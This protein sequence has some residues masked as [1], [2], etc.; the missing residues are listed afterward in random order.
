M[1]FWTRFSRPATET[2][3]AC[4]P[5]TSDYVAFSDVSLTR[6][7][8]EV[9]RNV[10]FEL[11]EQRIGL[12]GLN[13]SGK[14]S[15]VR[16]LNGLLLPESGEVRVLGASTAAVRAS[17]P[18]HV[19]FVFQNP[20]HQAIFPTVE[21][22]VVFGL[23]QLGHSRQ[24]AREKA[25]AY[26]VA[27]G[28]DHLA[29]KPFLD[30]SEG[31]KQLICILSVLVMEPEI[32]VL[33]EPFSSLDALACRKIM[34]RLEALP[35]K[36]IMISHDLKLIEGFDRILW[37]EEGQIRMDGTPETVLPA[38]LADVD[39]RAEAGGEIL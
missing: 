10:S 33:D 19:G 36:L 9:L 20:D 22:E 28:C 39:A 15:L 1:A 35:Q 31:Q 5:Q 14:S 13:G 3:V 12:V 24:E 25:R 32:L 7:G 17:L 16:L 37:L 27:N 23:T 2:R 11:R 30:L 38:Y 34:A 8:K 26:L 29:E 6:G 21:E 4:E 18:K